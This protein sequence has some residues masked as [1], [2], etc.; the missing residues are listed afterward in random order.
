MMTRVSPASLRLAGRVHAFFVHDWSLACLVALYVAALGVVAAVC[1][2]HFFYVGD[3]P[4]SFIPLWHHFGTELRSGRWDMMEPGGW[5]GGNYAGEAAYAQWN[6]LLIVAYLATSLFTDL[7]LAASVV[8]I[9]MLSLLG[10][11]A[12]L[13]MRAFSVGKAPSF[14]L[15][16]ALPVSGFTL[17]YEAAGWPAGLAAFVGVVYFWLAVQKQSLGEW[18]PLVTFVFGFLA[19]TTGNPYA[20]LGV[21]IVLAG[22]FAEQLL[23]RRWAA[24]RHLV[25]VGVL[26]GSSALLVYLPLLGVQ[27]V[28]VRQE[29]AGL[30]NDTFMVPDLGDLAGASTPSY[31][32]TITNWGGALVEG[33]PSTYLAWFALPLL[34]W[35]RWTPMLRSVAA[36]PSVA[37]IGL[38]Y[39]VAT[40]GPSN[41]WLFRWP[42]RL[43]EYLYLVIFIVLGIGITQ[44]LATTNARRRA[45][46]SAVIVA[47]GG[48]LAF[49]ATPDGAKIHVV[50]LALTAGLLVVVAMSWRRM[51]LIGAM[52]AI[53]VGTIA[54]TGFQ[55]LAYPRGNP[56]IVLPSNLEEMRLA[57]DEYEGRVL[58]LAQQPLAGPDAV[59]TGRILFG[60]LPA[61][62]PY[63]SVNRYSG[64]SFRAFSEALC[65]DYKGNTCNDAYDRLWQSVPGTQGDLADAIGIDT[66]VLQ[67]A[68][69][70]EEVSAG[71]PPGWREAQQDTIRA[72]WVRDQQLPEN[73]RVTGTSEGVEAR[74]SSDSA[75]SETVRVSADE[76]GYVTFARLAW[77]GYSVQLDGEAASFT[78]TEEGLLQVEVPPGE[79]TLHIEYSPP[80]ISAGWIA[81]G[82][83]SLIAA[84]QTAF[85]YHSRRTLTPR[86]KR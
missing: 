24:A 13:L 57:T 6:P 74:S 84:F 31:L 80:G 23:K 33:L 66:L 35:L 41:L 14:A 9:G 26:V 50:G 22:V 83:A 29:L 4:E 20:L 43:I 45:L 2:H 16:G 67:R 1:G 18:P 79:S 53:A 38:I 58:Q 17:F 59:N 72:V 21:L 36:M 68:A 42:I 73:G 69:F 7:A 78:S 19:V 70:E 30:V 56:T 46:A 3:N 75:R 81:V 37:I 27:P 77:P 63:E 64:I 55:T 49:A 48:F 25:A 8:M 86:E 82:I 76:P 10:A 40:L 51:G 32:P 71:P 34:P 44:G 5:M 12:Y 52:A 54:V 39:L 28:T 85:W 62:L 11:G 60:N 65:L 61:P 47:G 15:A